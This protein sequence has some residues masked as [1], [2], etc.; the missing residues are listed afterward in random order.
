MLFYYN[1]ELIFGELS[2][3]NQLRKWLNYNFT[4]IKIKIHFVNNSHY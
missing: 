2:Y 3:V 1:R 4:M